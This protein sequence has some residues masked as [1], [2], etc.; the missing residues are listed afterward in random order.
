MKKNRSEQ[1]KKKKCWFRKDKGF[2]LSKRVPISWEGYL[3]LFAFLAVNFFSVFYFKL[4]YTDFD[5]YIRFF[6]VLLLS[7]FVFII[8]AKRKTRGEKKDF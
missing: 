4:P 5:S 6:I 1:V 8:I 7:V 2:V 3:V